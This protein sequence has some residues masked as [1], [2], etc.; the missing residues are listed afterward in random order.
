MTLKELLDKYDDHSGD[1]V[2]ILGDKRKP[3]FPDWTVSRFLELYYFAP[4][5]ETEVMF[6]GFHEERFYIRIKE[7]ENEN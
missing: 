4:I 5:M 1:K 7:K 2:T 3:L 6:F